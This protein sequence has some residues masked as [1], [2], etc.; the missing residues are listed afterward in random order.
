MKSFQTAFTEMLNV[1]YP[2]VM[3]PMFLVSN[4][5]MVKA[6]IKSGIAG[7]FPS[8]NYR[9]PEELTA[10]L[11]SLR[12]TY[13]TDNTEKGTYGVNMI[14]QKTNPY[15]KKH[16]KCC[17]DEGVP[18]YITSLGNP[19]EVIQ[20]AHKT[21]A[22]VFCDITNL[23]H[24]K[25]VHDLGCDGFVSVTQGAGGHAGPY[26]NQ[27]LIPSLRKR[28]PEKPVLAAG[29][30]AN[31]ESILSVLALG[32]AA[33]YLGTRFIACKEATVSEEYKNAIVESGMEDIVLT[34]KLSGTPCNVINTDYAKKIGYRQGWIEKKLSTNRHTKKY[35]KMLV[36]YRGMNWLEKSVKPGSYKNLWSAG[37]SVELID[38]ILSV[39]NIVQKLMLEI[40]QSLERLNSLVKSN[41]KVL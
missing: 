7:T 1:K 5:A 32:A 14:V 34:E 18:F 4:E 19:Q 38:E 9:E 26:P 35:I 36:Q 27:L 28:F 41:E 37:Q 3:A 33:G 16:L 10:V 2:I 39:D 21:G 15:Y 23:E 29:G 30:L 12:N 11:K 6:A 17:L 13:E 20:E 40:H 31:G 24:A 25:K 8:L 22:K